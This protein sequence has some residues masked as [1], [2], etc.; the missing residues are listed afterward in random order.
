VP[1]GLTSTLGRLEP[2]HGANSLLDLAELELA[3]QAAENPLEPL[4]LA[5][6]NA[7]QVL[8]D[9][10]WNDE[11]VEL[12][13]QNRAWLVEQLLIMAWDSMMP[14]NHEYALVAVGGFGRGELHP[15]SDVDLMILLDQPKPA[16]ELKGSIEDFLALLWD[17]GL[18]LGHSV[19]T[20]DQCVQESLADVITATTLME[21]RLLAGNPVLFD[22]MRTAVSS[23][24]MWTG[25]EFFEAKYREQLERHERFHATAY[26]LEPNIKEGPGGLRDIQMISWVSKRHL[27][28]DS[29]HGLVEHGFL[30][31]TEFNKL[32]SGQLFLWRVRF[33]LHLLSGRA[34]DRLLFDYQRQ[35][36]TKL[37]YGAQQDSNE[38]VEN[39]MQQYYRVV[40]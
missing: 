29:L 11:P 4:K 27:A 38:G 23:D 33:A 2:G 20:I 22:E 40:M 5:L 31:E 3:L 9:Q 1:T 24:Q 13:V 12:L 39:F 35:I 7:D 15:Q 8:A 26:N 16:H 21:S 19:R 10:F 25:Q 28:T 18:Y 17:T 36:A 30:T 37:G 34:E 14:D 6:K 32:R